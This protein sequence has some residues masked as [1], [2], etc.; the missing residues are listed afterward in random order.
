MTDIPSQII[1]RAIDEN[2]ELFRSGVNIKKVF[3]DFSKE[4][5]AET[6]KEVIEGLKEFR[7]DYQTCCFNNSDEQKCLL[8]EYC[9]ER[10]NRLIERLEAMG[11]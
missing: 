7:N 9:Q 5:R 4:I 11:K 6:I 3:S 2:Y 8:C 10:L 1:D